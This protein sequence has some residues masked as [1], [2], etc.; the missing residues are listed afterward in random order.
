MRKFVN[1]DCSIMFED[2]I[3]DKQIEKQIGLMGGE[4]TDWKEVKE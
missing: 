4:I 1:L 2:N 3:T